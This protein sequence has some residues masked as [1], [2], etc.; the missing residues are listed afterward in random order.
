MFKNLIV[1]HFTLRPVIHSNVIF[2]MGHEELV[3]F[4][5]LKMNVR[6]FWNMCWKDC[7][8]PLSVYFCLDP[9]A[10]FVWVYFDTT[11]FDNRS[12]MSTMS[13][14]HAKSPTFSL[15][16]CFHYSNSFFFPHTFQ[17]HLL[18]AKIQVGFWWGSCWI[19]R[20]IWGKFSY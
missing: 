20:S 8:F 5:F 15:S 2:T 19:H 7:S 3:M 10:I 17:I 13:V 12:F 16:K 11:L 4:S 1:V 18:S 6:L 14:H 9:L